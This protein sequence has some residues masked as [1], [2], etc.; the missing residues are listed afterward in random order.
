[1]LST[2][3]RPGAILATSGRAPVSRVIRSVTC[4]RY[5]HV[6]VVAW[7]SQN[8]LY[9]NWPGRDWSEWKARTMVFEATTLDN[10]PCE[11]RGEAYRGLQAHTLGDW[12]EGYPGRVWCLDMIP[13]VT[14][15]ES[16]RLTDCALTLLRRGKL[17]DD[18]SAIFAGTRL[19]KWLPCVQRWVND[20]R[21]VYCA[22]LVESLLC[23]AL[24]GRNLPAW[25]PGRDTPRDTVRL[26]VDNGWSKPRRMK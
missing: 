3:A 12:V 19:L 21:L 24:Y 15:E 25:D 4:S 26:A 23:A 13:P 8:A 14:G 10:C 2:Y 20:R 1:M 18:C 7:V 5:S 9:R 6:A 16:H 22:E 11:I 17:Y